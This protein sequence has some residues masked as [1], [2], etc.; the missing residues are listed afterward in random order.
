MLK[1]TRETLFNL[2]ADGWTQAKIAE[3]YLVSKQ[4]VSTD[5]KSMGIEWRKVRRQH[6]ARLAEKIKV[7]ANEGRTASE[8]AC[9]LDIGYQKCLHIK[10]D[11]GIPMV[12]CRSKKYPE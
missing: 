8:I 12:V 5:I 7:L 10:R 4:K 9:E 11:Y 2:L 3:A 1:Y 6:R